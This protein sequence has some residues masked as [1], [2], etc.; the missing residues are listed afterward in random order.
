MRYHWFRQ[1][2]LFVGSGVVEASCKT[3]VGQRLKQSGMHWTVNGAD[4]I[5][6]LR[7]RQASSTWGG[8]V[9]EVAQG[10]VQL[11]FPGAGEGERAGGSHD[12]VGVA[13]VQVFQ[14]GGEPLV[15]VVQQHELQEA[16]QVVDVL[17]GVV[18]V[19]DLGC[20]G[21]LAAGDAPDPGRAV[22]EDGEL[23]D[24][25]GAAADASALT[26]PASTLAGSK[27]AMTLAGSRLRTG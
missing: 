6:A 18:E 1:C 14:P 27:V 17:A 2:G 7:C 24:V 12:A 20:L 15:F 5:I 16:G 19:D 9:L 26:G 22:T 4:A 23:P 21:E 3:I 8:V 10:G 13:V 11:V 25:A